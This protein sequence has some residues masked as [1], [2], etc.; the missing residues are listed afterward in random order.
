M[1]KT[2]MMEVAAELLRDSHRSDR[3]LAKV[4]RTSQPTVTRIRNKLERE[5]S[6]QEYTIIPH[7]VK[8]GFEILAITLTK[9]K[10]A[11]ELK[12][13][14]IKSM[15]ANPNV[16]MCARSEGLGKNAVIVSLHRSYSDYSNFITKLMEEWRDTIEDYDSILIS[17]GGIVLKP[18][19]LKSLAE[20]IEK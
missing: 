8:M 6:I 19:S 9:T 4:L 2:M 17:L 18:F 5:G 1:R 12:E 11:P 10:Y 15:M 13:R 14:G 7:F 3:E 16:V 20:L